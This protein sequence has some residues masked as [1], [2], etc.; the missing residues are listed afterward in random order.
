[1]RVREPCVP[2]QGRG[3]VPVSTS[4]LYPEWAFCGRCRGNGYEVFEYIDDIIAWAAK[5]PDAGG[6]EGQ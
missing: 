2:C 1:M 3:T 6:R 4:T 5:Q